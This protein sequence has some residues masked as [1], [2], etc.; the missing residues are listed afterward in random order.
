M[1]HK[2]LKN[3]NGITIS[4]SIIMSVKKKRPNFRVIEGVTVAVCGFVATIMSFFSIARPFLRLP[5]KLL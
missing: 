4:D 2:K 1:K 3:S 5:V